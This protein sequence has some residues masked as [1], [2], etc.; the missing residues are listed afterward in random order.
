MLASACERIVL[1][2]VKP[3]HL[4]GERKTPGHL[5]NFKEPGKVNRPEAALF[6]IVLIENVA[7][8]PDSF[9]TDNGAMHLILTIRLECGRERCF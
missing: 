3:T 7:I 6:Q 1:F 9:Q 5:Q 2:A 4:N 8:P